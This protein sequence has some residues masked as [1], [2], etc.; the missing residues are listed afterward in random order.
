MKTLKNSSFVYACLVLIFTL[1]ISFNE[2]FLN[3]QA[4]TLEVVQ[5]TPIKSNTR[6][7]QF[8]L[9][10]KELDKDEQSVL[11]SNAL[12]LS[13]KGDTPQAIKLYQELIQ[14]Q[15]NHQMAAINLVI[16]L[17]KTQSG[18]HM[19]TQMQHA[20]NVS[21]GKRKAKAHS[22][23]ASCLNENKQYTKA[24]Y[25]L[26][27]SLEFR[28]NHA[29]TWLKRAL[30]QQKAQL[31]FTKVIQ[32]YGQALAM[33]DKNIELRLDM[34]RYQQAHLDFDGSIKTIKDK[35]KSL[36]NSIAAH[37][38]LTWSYLE[39]DKINNAKKHA[40]LVTTLQNKESAFNQALM[41]FLEGNTA[42][43]LEKANL[44]KKKPEHH[45]LLAKI[46]QN[47][48]WPNHS[49]TQLSKVL[50][51]Q[52]NHQYDLRVAW[53]KLKLNLQ[54]NNTHAKLDTQ[55]QIQALAQFLKQDIAHGY[56]AY[57]AS[58]QAKS[59]KRF[60]D[61][62]KFIDLAMG[63]GQ[64]KL[65]SRK[66]QK[67]FGEILWLNNQKAQAIDHLTK[68]SAEHPN[69][70]ST[71]RLL[72]KYLIK[73]QMPNQALTTLLSIKEQERNKKDLF[74]LASLQSQLNLPVE[75]IDNL[76]ELLQRNESHIEARFLLA[77][78]LLNSNQKKMGKKHLTLLLKLDQHHVAAQKLYSQV[79]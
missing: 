24:L 16:L 3:A 61:A 10:Q 43:A 67:L 7:L 75:A 25:H 51:T 41:N 50:K 14:Q 13:R 8:D 60:E 32:S 57:E 28:P 30:I 18:Q 6:A 56:V 9:E 78:L 21:R 44:L 33:D 20:I 68:L 45:Y 48:K 64:N 29:G 38:I 72:A 79:I 27:K 59:L 58:K 19:E 62:K 63:L 76:T 71:K 55:G 26:D 74:N 22:L 11:F 12:A 69:S 73:Q 77:K 34:A 37:Q 66:K 1:S 54:L 46:Y 39:I 17:K 15:P 42:Q 2:R 49:N 47:K 4:K 31:P 36:K 35:Y 40:N 5:L 23:F 53:L 65:A 52:K 70:R